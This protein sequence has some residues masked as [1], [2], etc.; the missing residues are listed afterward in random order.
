MGVISGHLVGWLLPCSQQLIAA[1]ARL[2][3]KVG[4]LLWLKG[5]HTGLLTVGKVSLEQNQ[6][7]RCTRRHLNMKPF[8]KIHILVTPYKENRGFSVAFQHG[9]KE[10]KLWKML[11][12]SQG[13][14]R[15]NERKGGW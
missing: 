8:I 14:Q 1:R 7:E 2:C 13:I 15:Q 11:H 12:S 3:F 9:M 5:R 6:R 4:G 10:I